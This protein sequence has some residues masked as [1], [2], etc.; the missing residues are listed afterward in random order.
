M[1]LLILGAGGFATEVEELA[2]T[3]GYDNI[4]FLDDYPDKARCKPVIGRMDDCSLFMGKFQH[5]IVAI[6]NNQLRSLWHNKIMDL[7]FN[8]PSLVSLNAYVSPDAK[9]FPGCIVRQFCVVGRK[10]VIGQATILNINS[11][12]DHDCV[13]GDYSHLLIG[14]VVRNSVVL[15]SFSWLDSNAVKQ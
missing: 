3:L 9:L 7:G 4:C 10:A 12:V 11:K 5:A 1:N 2:R 6:G 8:I 13:I 14:A 15:P